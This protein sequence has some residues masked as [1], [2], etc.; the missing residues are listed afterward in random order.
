ME[1]IDRNGLDEKY[2]QWLDRIETTHSGMRQEV[3]AS[4]TFTPLRHPLSEAR[5]AL[6]TTAGAHL[7]DQPPFHTETVAGDH[8]WRLIPDDADLT[9]IRFS[10]TH[11]D[12][13]SAAL[14]PNVVLPVDRLHELVDNGRLGNASPIHIGMM[15]FNPDPGPIIDVTG[16][17]VASVLVDAEVDVA[18]LVPG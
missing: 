17:S 14:D 9:R 13:S 11:Y 10:H 2:S 6:V 4:P 3:E 16:P 15:G 18:I 5:V 7:D 8:S 12:T 1:P